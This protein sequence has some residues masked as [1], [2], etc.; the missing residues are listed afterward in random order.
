MALEDGAYTAV[1]D[2]FEDRRAVL[3]VEDDGEDVAE[4]A[5]HRTWVP[6]DARRQDAVVEL[7]VEDGRPVAVEYDPAETESRRESAQDRF[8]RLARR[9]GDDGAGES[10]ETNRKE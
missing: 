7:V 3:V 8:D 6:A 1:L 5:V 2:R 10:G 4:V 9:P